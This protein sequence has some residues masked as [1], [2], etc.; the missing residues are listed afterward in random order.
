MNTYE[1]ARQVNERLNDG[2]E[3]KFPVMLIAV[4]EILCRK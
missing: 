4:N 1:L 2:D 3:S